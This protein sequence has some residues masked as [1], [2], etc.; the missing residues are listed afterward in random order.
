MRLRR[1]IVAGCVAVLLA[2]GGLCAGT[3]ASSNACGGLLGP[4]CPPSSTQTA[5]TSTAASTSTPAMPVPPPPAGRVTVALFGDSVTQSIMVPNFVRD[6]LAGQLQT[7]LTSMGFQPGG[8]GFVPAAPYQF[9]FNA[10]QLI[11]QGPPPNGG[12]VTVGYGH[13]NGQYGPNGYSAITPW[14]QATATVKVSDPDV[15]VLYTSTPFHCPFFVGA[16]AQTWSVDT[17]ASTAASAAEAEVTLPPGTTELTVHGPSCGDLTFDG[18]VAH[19]PVAPGKVQVEIDNLG[20]AAHMAWTDFRQGEQEALI[21]QRYSISVFMWGYITELAAGKGQVTPYLT[22]MDARARIARM[23]GGA[24]LIVHPTPIDT[25]AASVALVQHLDQTV[26]TREGCTYT[27]VLSHLWPSWSWAERH[28]LLL[29]DG[30]H[31]TAAGY[32]EIAQALAP[33]IAPLVRAAA[34]RQTQASQVRSRRLSSTTPTAI[35]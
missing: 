10:D 6:G 12:W 11:R 4:G 32:T 33:V 28:G 18:I 27:S 7:Q 20:H 8:L 3:A 26:A 2:V 21:Q 1:T 30:V 34:R 22:T 29:V 25:T 15:D 23:D 31:P 24:C 19:Q 5:T 17:Y 35:T 9:T 14:P 13:V 16:A